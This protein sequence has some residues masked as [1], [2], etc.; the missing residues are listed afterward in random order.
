MDTEFLSFVK[1]LN[2][3]DCSNEL[4]QL[5]SF[6]REKCVDKRD[7]HSFFV[8][9]P[10]KYIREFHTIVSNL[11]APCIGTFELVE[12]EN[13]V[14][15]YPRQI[16]RW[17][18]KIVQCGLTMECFEKKPHKTIMAAM[19]KV[20]V[21]PESYPIS[22]AEYPTY[23]R[24]GSSIVK[25]WP[26]T[27]H[28]L[29]GLELVCPEHISLF[30]LVLSLGSVEQWESLDFIIL[31]FE[32]CSRKLGTSVCFPWFEMHRHSLSRYLPRLIMSLSGSMSIR[33]CTCI[34]Q[35]YLHSLCGISIWV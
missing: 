3:S 10:I 11:P 25:R 33:S 12:T 2:D 15:L 32:R 34:L 24:L 16:Y 14:Y 31:K 23:H 4:K 13:Y 5:T 18:S 29:S 27:L 35:S 19:R 28:L 8:K 21:C 20:S 17:V 30:D 9:V 6:L 1:T 26:M 7:E 22:K